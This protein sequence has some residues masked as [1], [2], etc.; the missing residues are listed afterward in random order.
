MYMIL[1]QEH[2][3]YALYIYIITNLFTVMNVSFSE[4]FIE[5]CFY[6]KKKQEYRQLKTF[7]LDRQTSCF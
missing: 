3:K 2:S 4:F 5:V 7:L 6:N 1:T